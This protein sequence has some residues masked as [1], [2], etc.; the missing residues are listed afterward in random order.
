[1]K[2]KTKWLGIATGIVLAAVLTT[3]GFAQALWS[4]YEVDKSVPSDGGQDT[5]NLPVNTVSSSARTFNVYK[6]DG[7][8]G[9]DTILVPA[10]ATSV[11]LT[12]TLPPGD[13]NTYTGVTVTETNNLGREVVNHDVVYFYS[14]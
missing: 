7:V 12:V 6:A 2:R 11:N 4:D 1:M 10:N 14:N 9:P 3:A 13:P 8:S 5:Q